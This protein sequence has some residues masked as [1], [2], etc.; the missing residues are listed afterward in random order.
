MTWHRSPCLG[1]CEQAP[2][3]FFTVAGANADRHRGGSASTPRPSCAGWS[4]GPRRRRGRWPGAHPSPDPRPTLETLRRSIP[5]AGEPSLRLIGRIGRVDPADLDA[6]RA[7]GGFDGL[8]RAIELGPAG[9]IAE[10]AAARLVGRGGAAFPTARK[11]EAVAGQAA[12]PHYLVCN[13]DESEPG[14]FKDRLLMEGDPF[15]VVEGMAIA[16]FATGAERGYVYIRAEYPGAAARMQDAIDAA[17]PA[18]LLGYNV[19]DSGWSFEIEVRRG[20]GAYIAGEE[21]ALFESIEGDRAEPR[22]KPPFPVT[23]GLFGKPTTVNNVETLANVPLILREGGAALRDDRHRGLGRA[24]ALLP[25]G[26][27]REGPACTRC[28]SGRRCAS[29]IDLAGGV[30]G[31]RAIQAVL[32]GGAAGAFVGPD[33][34]DVPLTFEGTR[35]IGATLGSGVVVV[36]DETADLVDALLRIAAVLPRRVVRPV[37]PVS[38]RN[39]PPGRGAAAAGLGPVERLGATRTWR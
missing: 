21:T 20:A 7:E 13:A 23:H 16:A 37:R 30:P 17:R 27:H 36:Y 18:G 39:G 2:A 32:L 35:A 9:T 25:L 11:W 26:P 4:T 15:A 6:Y 8:R 24:Q 1:L 10:V 33:E 34:L 22:N 19:L 5:Q 38:G 29:C 3:A 31:G 12:Q 14:T 28:R